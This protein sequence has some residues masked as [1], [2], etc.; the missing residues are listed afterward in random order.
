M[1]LCVRVQT[2]LN[3]CR[4]VKLAAVAAG[5][6]IGHLQATFFFF[7]EGGG[8]GELSRNF[9]D[10]NYKISGYNVGWGVVYYLLRG[11]GACQLFLPLTVHVGWRA[12]RAT[13]YWL[14]PS[15]FLTF[16]TQTFAQFEGTTSFKKTFHLNKLGD[17]SPLI[18]S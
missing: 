7:W 15:E 13:V 10:M 14:L 1:A 9:L 18:T 6:K 17:R 12:T 5:V 3:H 11:G 8:R 2:T 4:F 16:S